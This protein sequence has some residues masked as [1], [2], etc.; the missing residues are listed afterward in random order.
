MKTSKLILT[1]SV[2]ILITTLLTLIVTLN[3]FGVITG[4][5]TATGDANLSIST[6]AS[7]S[8]IT[9]NVNFGSGSVDEAPSV[10]YLDTEGGSVNGSWTA[11]TQGLTL[12]NDGN[13]NVTIDLD[14]S[15]EA[16]DF[17]GGTSPSMK[18]KV[19]NNESGSCDSI[20]VSTYTEISGTANACTGIGMAPNDTQDTLDIDFNLSIPEDAVGTKGTVITATGT[21]V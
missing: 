20:G 21:A 14:A 5:A 8:F 4:K 7:I 12:R 16:A 6:E 11:P 19:S 2:I 15:N 17:I 13:T 3:K 9:S 18:W 1:L 10:A